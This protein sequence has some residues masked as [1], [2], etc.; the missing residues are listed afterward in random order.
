MSQFSFDFF[1]EKTSEFA[2]DDF[3]LLP[4]N[5]DAVSYVKRILTQKDFSSSP[6][7]SL[8]IKGEKGSG[9]THLLRAQGANLLAAERFEF[10]DEE[11]IN[12]LN[13]L[14]F[15][16]PNHFYCFENIDEISNEEL[17]LSLV[18]SAFEANAFLILTSNNNKQF[19]LKDLASRL[20]NITA[21]EIKNPSQETIKQLLTN[22]L[23]RKQIALPTTIL[24]LLH[25][26]LP[27]SYSALQD[28][29]KLMEF[30]HQEHNE[31][32][33]LAYVKKI[34]GWN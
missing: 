14:Q 17:L 25:N 2:Q 34:F 24:N 3:L 5:A 21:T 9:K 6:T 1:S 16:T 12:G 29:M 33:D 27:R 23:S 30:H 10:L 15:L 32:F 4:E 28:A 18:N 7:T 19:Q 11:K 26:N 20:R 8:I 22:Q 31:K 13:L